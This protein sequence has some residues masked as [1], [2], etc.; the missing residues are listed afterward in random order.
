MSVPALVLLRYRL[1]T[2]D[3]PF[4]KNFVNNNS[5]L[6]PSLPK[7]IFTSVHHHFTASLHHFTLF[8]PTTP[9]ESKEPVMSLAFFFAQRYFVQGIATTGLK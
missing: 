3:Y 4:R 5:S 7:N 1:S 2:I 8:S 9:D 6:S